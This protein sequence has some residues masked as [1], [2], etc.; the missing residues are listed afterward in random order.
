[1]KDQ[2]ILRIEGL[3]KNF[4][5]VAALKEVNLEIP[6][7][8]I[9]ALVGENGAGKSTLIKILTGLYQKDSGTI[10]F[11]GDTIEPHD[12]L[13]AEKLG[14]TAIQQEM[15]FIPYM[16]IAENIYLGREI[17]KS[18][19]I[20][21]YEINRQARELL[22]SLGI[23]VDVTGEM[24]S[25]SAAVQQMVS[26]AR[27]ISINAKLI[28]MDEPT[29]SL[30]KNEVEVLFKV[31]RD[32]KKRGIT[33]IFITHRMNELYQ[34][35]DSLTVLRD[36]EVVGQVEAS[37]ITQLELVS[38]M[39]G[40]DAADIMEER[41]K[42][43]RNFDRSDEV[44]NAQNIS[45]FPK[46]N[47]MDL[48]VARGEVLG[49]AGLLGSGR[50]EVAR[51]LFGALQPDSADIAIYGKKVKLNNTRTAKKL[52]LGFCTEDRKV[53]GN[54][55]NMSVRDNLTLAN[56]SELSR[57]GVISNKKRDAL[58]RE[59]I[60]TFHI[61][62]SG[63]NQK[64]VNLSGG[65]QQKVLLSRW[66]S[67]KPRILILDEPTR[68]I[69]VG[70]KAEIEKLIRQLAGDGIAIILISS[71]MEELVRMS[72]RVIVIREG[73]KLGEL[74]GKHLTVDSIMKEIA[75]TRISDM[76]GSHEKQ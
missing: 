34:M 20:D 21:W 8:D 59:Y 31:M 7:G 3:N 49:L 27:A 22:L 58:V 71:E 50:S 68:G 51:I 30:D 70:A 54:I 35:C 19:R 43:E 39:I 60:K 47:K 18:G 25:Q 4:F 57:F 9:H 33:L 38:Q 52:K 46:V 72:D 61:K 24:K 62:T 56:L 6:R 29:S 66:I 10:F 63:L 2:M 53:D 37:E 74:T 13:A 36:G 32:L 40:Q 67:T 15:N 45:L 42:P 11:D 17:K 26:L 44:L 28:I 1:M 76:E 55:P 23:D 64:M 41:T 12:V 75:N 48:Q 69:D 14:I 5:G 73:Y 16:S 65:N